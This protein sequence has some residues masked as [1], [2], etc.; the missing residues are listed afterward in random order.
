VVV[1]SGLVCSTVISLSFLPAALVE[2]LNRR[3]Q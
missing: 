2:L 1:L 3:R